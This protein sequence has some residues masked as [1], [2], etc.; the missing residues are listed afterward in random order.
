MM[1]QSKRVDEFNDWLTLHAGFIAL[2]ERQRK[3]K[4]RCWIRPIDVSRLQHGTYYHL[5]KELELTEE[6]FKLYFRLNKNQFG[7]VLSFVEEC[8]TKQYRVREPICAKQRLA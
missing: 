2:R 3:Q 6:E 4:R 1:S 5:V 7:Y 8:L